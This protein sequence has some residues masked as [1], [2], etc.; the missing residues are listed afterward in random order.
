[1]DF[2]FSEEQEMLRTSVRAFLADKCPISAVRAAYG[3]A[4]FDDRSVWDGLAELGVL[5]LGMVDAAVVLEELGRAVS[6]APYASSVI[7]ARS[8]LPDLAGIGTVAIYE[9]GTRYDWARPQTRAIR[10]GEMWRL[11]GTKVHVADATAADVFVVT[12]RDDAGDLQLFETASAAATVEPSASIDGSRKQGVV[13][14]DGSPARRL[15]HRD[16]HAAVTRMLDRLGVAYAVDGVGA[17]QRSLELAVEYA[18]E[19]VQFDRPIGAF[20]AVQHLCADML[21]TVELGRAAAYYA[22]WA[23]EEASP[24]EAHRAATLARAYAADAFPQVGGTAIQVFGGIGFT[25]EHDIHLYFKRLLTLSVLL[26][27][28]GDHLEELATIAIE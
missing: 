8:L 25:W 19:R 28:A 16:P 2:E 23:L 11:D 10:D 22:C 3:T 24:E 7:G 13:V 27:S 20:Q 9:T 1:M 12:A 6:P 26:G 15:P 4:T 14:L 17:A 5:E 18:K 21:R